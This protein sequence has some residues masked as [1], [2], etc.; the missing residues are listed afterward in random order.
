MKEV[1]RQENVTLDDFKSMDGIIYRPASVRLA[2]L[3]ALKVEQEGRLETKVRRRE[4]EAR[5]LK[6]YERSL[7]TGNS[8]AG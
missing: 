2:D 8:N 1:C 5:S 7:K 4:P 6:R 3:A